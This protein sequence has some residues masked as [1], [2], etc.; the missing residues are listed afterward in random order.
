MENWKTVSAVMSNDTRISRKCP[1]FG[2]ASD[3]EELKTLNRTSDDI[4]AVTATA[5]ATPTSASLRRHAP[6]PA[7]I[8]AS[9]RSSGTMDPVSKELAAGP[10]RKL[11]YPAAGANPRRNPRKPTPAATKPEYRPS[12]PMPI[13]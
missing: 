13:F 5:A 12:S 6:S 1:H 3:R 11:A 10:L 7:V 9:S 2:E 8:P 4:T